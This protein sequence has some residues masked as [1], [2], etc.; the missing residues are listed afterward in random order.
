MQPETPIA[1]IPLPVTRHLPGSGTTPDSQLLHSVSVLALSDTQDNNAA[2]NIAWLYGIRLFN[3]GYYWEAHEVWESVWMHAAHNS[4]E[5]S[6]VQ[7]CIHLTNAELKL[8]LSKPNAA[9]RLY[10]LAAEC[11]ERSVGGSAGNLMGVS[12]LHLLSLSETGQ[13]DRAEGYKPCIDC[14]YLNQEDDDTCISYQ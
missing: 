12:V 1:E 3:A 11:L 10:L 13:S 9:A 5:R 14:E 8:V 6:L 4:R 7:A 2:R